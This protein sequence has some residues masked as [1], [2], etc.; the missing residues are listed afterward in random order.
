LGAA[1]TPDRPLRGYRRVEKV[2]ITNDLAGGFHAC[3]AGIRRWV[4]H[5]G[6]EKCPRGALE[7]GAIGREGS[8]GGGNAQLLEQ[9]M[10]PIG[11][12][13]PDVIEE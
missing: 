12:Q 10:L 1:L 5:G 6:Y 3:V 8:G 9:F 11:R 7:G 13:A 2:A 4:D